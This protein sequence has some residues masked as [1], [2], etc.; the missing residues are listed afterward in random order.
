MVT[1]ILDYRAASAAVRL[2]NEKGGFEML[3]KNPQLIE[4]LGRMARAQR[5]QPLDAPGAEDEGKEVARRCMD[6]QA[7]AEI[8]GD[9]S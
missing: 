5:G 6:E 8:D 9:L 2:F 1:A 7:E 3:E 4:S